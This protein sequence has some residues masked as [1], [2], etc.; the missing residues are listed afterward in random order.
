E[1]AAAKDGDPT[2]P[3]TLRPRTCPLSPSPWLG[4]LPTKLGPPERFLCIPVVALMCCPDGGKEFVDDARFE[5][6]AAGPRGQGLRDEL[7]IIE[8]G[9]HH[10]LGHGRLALQ[11]ADGPDTT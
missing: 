10:H 9:Q 7:F 1:D 3:A 8:C 11:R 5:H 4:H 6:V 2:K